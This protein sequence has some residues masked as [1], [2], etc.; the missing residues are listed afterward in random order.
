M[1]ERVQLLARM[2]IDRFDG[3]A[4]AVWTT[5][6]DGKALLQNVRSL[7][8]F[9][10]QKARIFIALLGKRLGVTPPGWQAAAGYFGQAGTYFSV[11]DIDGPDALAQVRQH[12]AELKA[13]AK[14]V[15]P[16]LGKAPRAGTTRRP[17][18]PS[19]T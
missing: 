3:D 19:A 5:A 18:A 15:D 16:L 14:S 13:A 8:G 9:G 4:A 10:E 1:A 6:E 17:R 2:L 12:K 11:A 7:P